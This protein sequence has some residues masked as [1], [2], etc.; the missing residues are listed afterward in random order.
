MGMGVGGISQSVIFDDKGGRGVQTPH[1]KHDIINEQPLILSTPISYFLFHLRFVGGPTKTRLS[2]APLELILWAATSYLL[3]E[4]EE[5][6]YGF[7]ALVADFGGTLG[8]F[9]GFSFM[10]LWDVAEDLLLP[11]ADRLVKKT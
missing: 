9:I 6:V 4:Q 2:Q 8:L 3:V 10:T 5:Y 1:K 7:E 11:L